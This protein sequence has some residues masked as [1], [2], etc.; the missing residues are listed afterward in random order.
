MHV[1]LGNE[2]DRIGAVSWQRTMA[3]VGAMMKCGI[4]QALK[5]TIALTIWGL[6]ILILCYYRD[7]DWFWSHSAVP[8]ML[9]VGLA[10]QAG[11]IL[12]FVQGAMQ[13]RLKQL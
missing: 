3:R 10:V 4:T 13:G 9:G 5:A 11:C 12:G 1:G 7:G 8:L 6:G 2:Q